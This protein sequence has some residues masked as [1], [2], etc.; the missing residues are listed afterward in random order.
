MNRTFD[1]ITNGRRWSVLLTAPARGEQVGQS[2]RRPPL[3]L[4]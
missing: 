1:T 2:Y 4:P 3:S